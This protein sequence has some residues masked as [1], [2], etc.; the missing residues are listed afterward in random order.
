MGQGCM[1]V[2]LIAALI[3]LYVYFGR[4]G[5]A[6]QVIHA[7]VG[8]IAGPMGRYMVDGVEEIPERWAY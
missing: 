3:L 1:I 2:L 6:N 8:G 7:G 4:E 5:Y